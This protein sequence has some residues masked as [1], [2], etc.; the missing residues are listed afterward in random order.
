MAL[1]AERFQVGSVGRLSRDKGPDV[2][3]EACAHLRNLDLTVS[4][5]GDGRLG[6][7]LRARAA[8]QPTSDIRFH[9]SLPSA[10]RL[11]PAFDVLVLS[12]RTEGTPIVLFEAMEAGVPVVATCVGGVPDV[13][14]E[15]T[16]ILVPSECPTALADAIRAVHD[17]PERARERAAL[18]RR[19][20]LDRYGLGPWIDRY[21]ALY[22]SLQG[23]R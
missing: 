7:E 18:A 16:A 14:D 12:S 15:S 6:P 1:T 11:L 22:A 9:G 4:F 19:R 20:L 23:G 10:A 8:T 21:E 3:L 2:L 17:Y 5:V 13:I